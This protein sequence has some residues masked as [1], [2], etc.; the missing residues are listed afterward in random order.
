[1]KTVKNLAFPKLNLDSHFSALEQRDIVYMLNGTVKGHEGNS[2]VFVQN[3]LSNELCVKF[4]DTFVGAISLDKFQYI[5]GLKGSSSKLVL[6]NLE[7]C[8]QTELI[9][10]PCL[11]FDPLFPIR[12]VSKRL[13]KTNERIIYWVDGKNPNRYLNIDQTLLGEYPKVTNANDCLTCGITTT[14]A[15]DCNKIRLNKTH[16]PPCL[17]LK[18]NKQGNFPTG[19]YQVGI[20]YSED[21]ITFS[22]FYFSDTVKNQS[23][24]QDIGFTL[25]VECVYSPFQ[26]FTVILVSQTRN[27]QIVYNYG[28]YAQGTTSINISNTFNATILDINTALS[29]RV[30]YDTSSHIVTN[31]ETLLLGKH[32]SVEPL[33]Y[34]LL[35]NNIQVEWLEKKVPAVEAHLHKGFLRDET[36]DLSIEWLDELGRRR[37]VYHIPGRAIG[38]NYTLTTPDGIMLEDS[39]IPASLYTYEGLEPC[40]EVPLKVWQVKNTAYITK[41]VVGDCI[42]CL[43]VP[44]ITKVGKMGYYECQDLKYPDEDRWGSLRCQPIRRH[45][46]PSSDLT[47]IHNNGTCVT[48]TVTEILG[49]DAEN[50]PVLSSYDV[51]KFVPDNCINILGVRLRNVS[52][53]IVNGQ[54]M[55]NW[56]YRLLYSDRTGNKSILHKGLLYNVNKEVDKG[57]EIMYPNYPYNDL[58]KDVYL[59]KTQTIG[60]GDEGFPNHLH[61]DLY[62]KNRFTYHSPDIHYRETRNEFGTELKIYTE[63]VGKITSKFS[64]VYRHPKVGLGAS[65]PDTKTSHPYAQQFDSY[66]Q[67]ES[68]EVFQ[69][70]LDERRK[71]Q[72]SQWLY[73][74]KQ[75][76]SKGE[77]FNNKERETSYYLEVEKDVPN[78]TNEDTSRFTRGDISCRDNTQPCENI[79]IGDIVYPIQA[80]SYYVGVNTPQKNQY[81]N[82]NQPNYIPVESCFKTYNIQADFFGGDTYISRHSDFRKMPMFD[83]FLYDVPYTTEINYRDKRNVWYPTYWYDNLTNAGDK[84]RL[85]CFGE[86]SLE[87]GADFGYF[88]LWVTGC[89][90]YWCESEFIG[91]YREQ[92]MTPNSRFFPDTTFTEIAKSDNIQLQPTYLYD[93]SLL[94]KSVEE[95]RLSGYTKSDANFTVT[96]SLKNDLQSAGDNW[97]KFLPLNYTI[98][99]QIY[100][101]FTGL[102]YIDQYSIFFLFENMVLYSQEDYTFQTNEG[103]TI[104]LA[105]GDIFSKRLRKVANEFTGYSGSVDPNSFIN[106]RFGTFYLDRY[107]KKLFQWT[108]QLKELTGISSFLETYLSNVNPGYK[109]SLVTVY[110]NFTGMLFFTDKLTGWTISY[111]PYTDGFI[112]FHSFVPDWYLTMPN[113][114]CSVKNNGIWRHNKKYDYQRYYGNV[115]MFDIGFVEVQQEDTELQS[116]SVI[117][118]FIKVEGYKKFAYSKEFFDQVFVYNNNSSTGILNVFLKDRNDRT[119]SLSQNREGQAEVTRVKGNTF[120]VNKLENNHSQGAILEYQSNGMYYSPLNLVDKPPTLRETIKGKWNVIHLRTAQSDKIILQLNEPLSDIINQ[121]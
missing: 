50:Q 77:R 98:L 81:G 115:E 96:Y 2:E 111:S 71:I 104:F 110:D 67:F 22:D 16:K 100:G 42:A 29:K 94:N 40:A 66:A 59:S 15:L 35:A 26:Y 82:I 8:T 13:N 70:P 80:V 76:V 53:P 105:Q 55:T 17:N 74:I 73:P 60:S 90:Y 107:R 85:S 37:G 51:T 5:V 58:K 10:D 49:F 79:T 56:K 119:Q 88:Y 114:F 89:P 1:M 27:G 78:P 6:V 11:A 106:T 45:R 24:K 108:G 102:H 97:L 18:S 68:Y 32:Q 95:I 61:A 4:T 46:F 118:D 21:G 117:V 84:Y 91:N 38:P 7:N 75:F 63:E 36:Y 65:E 14:D 92:D 116:I 64:E 34:Q 39:D 113:N 93:F 44:T 20:A 19:T 47:H 54:S 31:D 72:E 109:N 83:E 112:S 87:N 57:T 9:N 52:P 3:M 28:E 62:Y 23:Y 120:N 121:K 43:E 69:S 12:G 33:E 41:T 25:S 86:N 101:E 30:I 99:P 48:T 103:N